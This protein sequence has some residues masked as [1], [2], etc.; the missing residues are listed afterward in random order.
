M[1]NKKDEKLID[2]FKTKLT[3]LHGSQS[4]KEVLENL[5]KLR[6][7][8][9]K[10]KT[11]IE[12]IKEIKEDSIKDY[13]NESEDE[14]VKRDKIEQLT[15]TLQKTCQRI[16]DEIKIGESSINK[17]P[18]SNLITDGNGNANDNG[19]SNNSVQKLSKKTVG[20]KLDSEASKV[21]SEKIRLF[22]ETFLTNQYCN[23]YFYL[24]NFK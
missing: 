10:C 21:F 12:C 24:L 18:N 19:I 11:K 17:S 6:G 2:A 23:N 3:E 1:E 20:D 7:T 22:E 5:K 13:L 16:E 15:K 9:Q 4:M 14:S 8:V